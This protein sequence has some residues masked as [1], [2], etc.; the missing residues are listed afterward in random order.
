VCFFFSL[1]TEGISQ[2]PENVTHISSMGPLSSSSENNAT[3]GDSFSVTTPE[4]FNRMRH[5]SM[6]QHS[7]RTSGH[8]A[9]VFPPT[10]QNHHPL[11]G[12][13]LSH[14]MGP[15][16]DG[17]D[18]TTTMN[19]HATI[20]SQTSMLASSGPHGP[21]F[22]IAGKQLSLRLRKNQIDKA[23]K[24]KG[25]KTFPENFSVTL[26]LVKPPEDQSDD[27]I[28]WSLYGQQQGMWSSNAMNSCSTITATGGPHTHVTTGEQKHQ[29]T[30]TPVSSASSLNPSENKPRSRPLTGESGA[31]SSSATPS[32]KSVEQSSQESA[33]SSDDGGEVGN[34]N[35]VI[36]NHGSSGKESSKKHV[37]MR[38]AA[39]HRVTSS[40]ASS[41]AAASQQPQS[42]WI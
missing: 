23:H 12:R 26:F 11:E 28:D 40:A 30:I 1:Q 4:S 37:K 3:S 19:N 20:T 39:N 33:T 42:T 38:S 35:D 31:S 29:F 13:S 36:R 17:H 27:L 7:V 6:P 22:P 2:A 34:G 32:L 8:P 10:H 25:Q 21:R 18:T 15:T 24:D 14:G 16:M 41:G 9:G 5:V